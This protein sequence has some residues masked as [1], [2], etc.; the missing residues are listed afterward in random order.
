VSASRN[1]ARLQV[2]SPLGGLDVK[3]VDS[4][5][6]VAAQGFGGLDARVDPGLYEL[7]L[8]AGQS[9]ETR[10]LK[11]E[12]GAL[13]KEVNV[14]LDVA[15]PAPIEGTVTSRE[16]HQHAARAAGER[17][18][19]RD[20]VVVMVRNLRGDDFPFDRR[21]LRRLRIVG[22]RLRPE[23]ASWEA[24]PAM[25][26]ATLSV[27][28]GRGGVAVRLETRSPGEGARYRYLPLWIVPD[29]QVFVFIPNTAEG[30]ALELATI[31]MA[32]T[33]EGWT[34]WNEDAQLGVALELALSGLRTGRPVVP[35]DLLDLLLRTKFRN[36]MLGV[37]GAHALLAEPKPNFRTLT[38]VLGNLRNLLRPDHPDVVGLMWLAQEARYS[39][40]KRK[41]LALRP[42]SWP[43]MFH[44]AYE[45]LLRLDALRPGRLARR[46]V[47]ESVAAQ[48]LVSGVWTTWTARRGQSGDTQAA[49]KA[50][51]ERVANYVRGVATLHGT[52]EVEALGRVNEGQT[53]LSVGLPRAVV[54]TAL[55]DLHAAAAKKRRKPRRS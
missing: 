45:A 48:I 26:F 46:S 2:E 38:T 51:T 31:H 16:P 1:P 52:D 43:P 7:Q 29:W 54:L 49:R 32:R 23:E 27:P 25:G 35:R 34:P 22:D 3:L 5:F 39:P 8:R 42:V 50:A 19:S 14:L 53:A 24:D 47:A 18:R 12:A 30:P 9:E 17:L 36:P 33:R 55:G 4:R 21:L 28:R 11:L 40:R 6:R 13:H 41:L 37:V 10:L 20:G 15:S 44:S